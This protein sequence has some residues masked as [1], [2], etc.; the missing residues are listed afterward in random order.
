MIE[1]LRN[2]MNTSNE[3]RTRYLDDPINYNVPVRDTSLPGGDGI[4]ERYKLKERVIKERESLGGF[5]FPME[6][7]KKR[8]N[9][10]D[11]YYNKEFQLRNA[12]DQRKQLLA[13]YTERQP[14]YTYDF[15]RND[16]LI[17]AQDINFDDLDINHSAPAND[18]LLKLLD[19]QVNQLKKESIEQMNRLNRQPN[20]PPQYGFDL[21]EPKVTNHFIVADNDRVQSIKH[22]Q[23]LQKP[24]YMSLEELQRERMEHEKKLREIEDEYYNRKS[25]SKSVSRASVSKPKPRGLYQTARTVQQQIPLTAEEQKYANKFQRYKN[26]KNAKKLG[27]EEEW[28]NT[29]IKSMNSNGV[30]NRTDGLPGYLDR[31]DYELYYYNIMD[32]EKKKNKFERPILSHKHTGKEK[33]L[34]RTFR[35]DPGYTTTSLCN[36]GKITNNFNSTTKSAQ[37]K[38][39]NAS[40]TKGMNTMQKSVKFDHTFPADKGTQESRNFGNLNQSNN[41]FQSKDMNRN[42]NQSSQDFPNQQSQNFPIQQSQNLS[43]HQSQNFPNQQS[44]A[45]T[46]SNAG[47]QHLNATSTN[48]LAFIKMIYGMLQKTQD[49]HADKKTILH[50]MNLDESSI[51]E[52]GFENE[53][54]FKNKLNSFPTKDNEYMSEE[55][56]TNFL[57][58]KGENPNLQSQN[59]YLPNS[60]SVNNYQDFYNQEEKKANFTHNNNEIYEDDTDDELPGLKTNTLDFLKKETTKGRLREFNRS[61]NLSSSLPHHAA[62]EGNQ[63]M[64]RTKSQLNFTVPKPFSF[65]KN[66]YQLK[67]L[68]KIKEIL[69]DRMTKESKVFNKTFHANPLN[70]KMFNKGLDLGNVI[71]R[72]KKQRKERTDK[73]KQEIIANMKPFSFYAQDEAKYKE[74]LKRECMPPQFQPFKANPIQ[75]KSQVNMYDGIIRKDEK[76]R[77][78]RIHERALQMFN[79]AKLPPRMEMHEKNKRIQEQEKK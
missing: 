50:D 51:K 25:R 23:T 47:S 37:P 34:Q 68:N 74:K 4:P 14:D 5:R 59:Y 27:Y 36:I 22:V 58:L 62:T 54:D 33:S 16:N 56:F 49:G 52:L 48:Q 29:K 63:S 21:N 44:Q 77:A 11:E 24:E 10:S 26:Q 79:E 32:E 9:P 75:W 46:N 43:N 31:D 1:N 64:I 8:T 73:L 76:T 3:F 13:N 71:Q 67:K 53:A 19:F 6:E 70:K 42:L 55:E 2:S 17:S 60:Q 28:N 41:S 69:E 45:L 78:E 72:E 66:N 18:N 39:S 40:N 15:G 7:L 38:N 12:L 20:D 57:L 30:V 65:L 61:F 35:N